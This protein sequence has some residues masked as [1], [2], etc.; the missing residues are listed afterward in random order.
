VSGAGLVGTATAGLRIVRFDQ[1]N[2]VANFPKPIRHTSGYRRG[3][4]KRLMDLSVK[5]SSQ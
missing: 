3:Y 5:H 1:R 4:A 2:D